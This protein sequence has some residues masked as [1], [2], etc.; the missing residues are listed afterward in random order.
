MYSS[1]EDGTI[2]YDNPEMIKHEPVVEV[3][4]DDA[5]PMVYQVNFCNAVNK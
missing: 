1:N 4:Q 3:T 5:N 2:D